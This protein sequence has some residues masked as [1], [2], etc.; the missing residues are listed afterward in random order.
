[1][2]SDLPRIS[3]VPFESTSVLSKGCSLCSTSTTGD[4]CLLF[5]VTYFSQDNF[6]VTSSR[7]PSLTTHTQFHPLSRPSEVSAASPDHIALSSPPL[8]SLASGLPEDSLRLDHLVSMVAQPRAWCLAGAQNPGG[9]AHTLPE[10]SAERTLGSALPCRNPCA[11][12]L[13]KAHMR[14]VPSTG[15]EI[16]SWHLPSTWI[17]C[18][19][20]CI[21]GFIYMPNTSP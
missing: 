6:D 7:K 17:P 14:G 19:A 4:I 5:P 10:S 9:G 8:Q 16:E 13:R 2:F 18:Q 15:L 3:S 12:A 21:C 1:M 11:V 20:A